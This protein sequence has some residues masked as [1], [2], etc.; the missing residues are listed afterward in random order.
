MYIVKEAWNSDGGMALTLRYGNIEEIIK[1]LL[2]DTLNQDREAL[3]LAL[4]LFDAYLLE[5][6]SGVKKRLEKFILEG[7]ECE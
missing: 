7:I 4:E 5:G 6:K 1:K 3:E 2:T